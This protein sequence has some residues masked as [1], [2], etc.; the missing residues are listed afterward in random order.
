[1]ERIDEID[2]LILAQLQ[3]DSS[4]SNAELARRIALSPPAVH[5]RIR[6]LEELGIIRRYVAL[7]DHEKVGYDIVCLISVVLQSHE[8]SRVIAFRDAV[9]DMSEVLECHF[10]TGEFDYLL[11]VAV[12]SRK[13]LEQ[14]LMEKLTP[15]P[16]IA[17]VSTS[18]VLTEVKH[19][20]ALSLDEP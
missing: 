15:L 5:A 18:I 2:K 1:M 7:L 16:G 19:T 17:R 4:I 10:I 8:M 6:R 20:T 12:R 13:H 11:K 14:W 9:R 3:Q